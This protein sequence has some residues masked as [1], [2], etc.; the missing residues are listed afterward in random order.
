[1][2]EERP[3]F[4]QVALELDEL[5]MSDNPPEVIISSCFYLIID[6]MGAERGFILLYDGVEH[7]WRPLTGRGVD[8]GSLFIS[9]AVS[10]TILNAVAEKK[11]CIITNNAMED[12]RF[13]DKLSVIISEI[14]SVICVPLTG[15][16]GLFGIIYL[17]NRF[18]KAY[19]VEQDRD[20]FVKLARK[21]SKTVIMLHPDLRYRP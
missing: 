12:P 10:Q 18:S 3:D 4:E 19:F 17:D 8:L 15:E 20:Y 2:S 11:T 9:E 14:R 21:L 5:V 7:E 16:K 6:A 1:M 13:S